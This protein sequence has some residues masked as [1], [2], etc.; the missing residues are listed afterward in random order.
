[1][2]IIVTEFPKSGGSWIVSMMADALQVPARDIYVRPGF[3]L[4][5]VKK[6]PWY[7]EADI[8]D[9]PNSSV[10][11]SHELPLSSLMISGDVTYVHLVRDGRD[12]VV[13]KF[14]FDRDFCVTNEITSS[15]EKNF[16]DYVEETALEWARYVSAW[17]NQNVLTV[18]YE[19]FLADPIEELRNLLDAVAKVRMDREHLEHV[20]ARFSKEK[21]SESLSHVFQHNTFVRKGIVGD[22]KNYFSATNMTAFKSVAGDALVAYKYEKDAGW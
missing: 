19:N 12:V 11:K 13:S 6:H 21:F 16:D 1:M 20:V 4:F 10:I 14:F 17:A 5:N 22:W 8:F 7:K 3:D 18:K 9:F 2:P 15:F